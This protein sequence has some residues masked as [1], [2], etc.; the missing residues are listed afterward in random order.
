MTTTALEQEIDR[1]YEAFTK[2]LPELLKT[3]RNKY[4]LIRRGEIIAL[5]NDPFDAR[6]TAERFFEDRLFSI[7][8]VTDVP[9]D[10]GYF[11]HA[12]RLG[13]V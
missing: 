6:M 7:Q 9:I 5:Y 12:V 1:N 8:K 2:C 10:L 11:S 3:D 13:H 4:A